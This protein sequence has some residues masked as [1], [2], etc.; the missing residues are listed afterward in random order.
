MVSGSALTASSR[1]GHTREA[2]VSQRLGN[3][4]SCLPTWR[5]D[6]PVRADAGREQFCTDCAG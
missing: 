5:R 3:Q 4:K 1:A 2:L 6:Q